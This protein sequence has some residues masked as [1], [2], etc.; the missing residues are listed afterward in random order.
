MIKNTKLQFAFFWVGQNI[1]IPSLLVK[2]IRIS[3]KNE[4]FIYQLTDNQTPYIEGVDKTIRGAL[5]KDIM[6]ARLKA[7]SNL[8]TDKPTCFLDADSL[9]LQKFSLPDFNQYRAFIIKRL[10]QTSLINHNFPEFYPEFIN[11]KFF[12]LMPIF[13]GF[14][15]TSNGGVFFKKLLANAKKM[16]ARFHRWYGDQMSLAEEWRKKESDFLVLSQNE[17]LFIVK[18]NIDLSL[19]INQNTKIITFKGSEAKSHILESYLQLKDIY[20]PQIK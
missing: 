17:Y 6:L 18:E 1:S 16:P 20:L 4:A 13:F 11:Q 9:V 8:K 15:A 7:Y 19:L 5:P 12:D 2:S 14:I 10:D 3:F